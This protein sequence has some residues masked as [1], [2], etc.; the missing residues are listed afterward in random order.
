MSLL[1][2]A[3][4]YSIN[5]VCIFDCVGAS[6]G[7][8][9]AECPVAVSRYDHCYDGDP[10]SS[11]LMTLLEYVL[12]PSVKKVSGDV[13][14]FDRLF[15]PDAVARLELE[16]QGVYARQL[17]VWRRDPFEGKRRAGLRRRRRGRFLAA[18]GARP[19]APANPDGPSGWP[20]SGQTSR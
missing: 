8:V 2:L 18:S 3:R 9:F 1:L 12:N 17:P 19:M 13:Q 11:C 4:H 10:L 15:Q 20:A 7:Q 16:H 5:V 6:G 14:S